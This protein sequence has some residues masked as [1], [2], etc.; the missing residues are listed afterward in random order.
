MSIIERIKQGRNEGQQQQ[1]AAD[2][3]QMAQANAPDAVQQNVQGR[4]AHG[5]ALRA[6]PDQ[7]LQEEQ[8][9]P[10]EQGVHVDLEKKLI[11]VVHGKGMT[12]QLLK[13]I[14]AAPDVVHGIGNVASDLV[15]KLKTSSPDA[16]DDVL[17]SIGERAVEEIVELVE[18]A[19][20][21]VDLDEDDLAEAY[22]IGIQNYMKANSSQVN[23]E[24]VRGFLANG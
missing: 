11:E 4:N 18:V 9:G 7:D 24:D 3:E 20:P 1:V 8:A 21:S 17:S 5:K 13:A 2:D 6:V 22:S 10:E 19:D 14:F 23:D 15:M 16:T 12:K